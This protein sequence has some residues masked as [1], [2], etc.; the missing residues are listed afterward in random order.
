ML[1]KDS[2]PHRQEI[3]LMNYSDYSDLE[4]DEEHFSGNLQSYD[5]VV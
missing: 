2:E 1:N 4:F 3:Y 5:P